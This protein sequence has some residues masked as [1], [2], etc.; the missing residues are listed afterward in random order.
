M[1]QPDAPDQVRRAAPPPSPPRSSRLLFSVLIVLGSLVLGYAIYA[2]IQASRLQARYFSG[3]ARHMQFK[4]EPGPSSSIRFPH[5]G[6][7]DQ[8]LGYSELPLYLKRLQAK[9]FEIDAQARVT[10]QLGNLIQAGYAPP[11]AEKTQAGLHI[12][13]CRREPLFNFTYPERAYRDFDSIPPT[14]V[15]SLLFIEN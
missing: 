8:R 9:G 3:I 10:F 14:V 6:P 7:Y 11:Y 15:Q 12:V 13:D 2:E 1:P 4:V 5:G